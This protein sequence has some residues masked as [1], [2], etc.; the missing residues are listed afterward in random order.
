MFSLHCSLSGR[1]H[2]YRK[3]TRRLEDE[4]KFRKLTV[5]ELAHLLKNKLATIQSIIS[6]RLREQPQ[7]RDEIISSL[8]ALMATDDL[9]MAMQGQGARI[10]DILTAELAP[11]GGSSKLASGKDNNLVPPSIF[12]VL[13][14]AR[15]RRKGCRE[16]ELLVLAPP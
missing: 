6:F 11:Y 1:Y 3:L 4:E 8:S 5:E 14:M 10:R 12:A 16:C 2:H 9:I 15:V 7:A 13:H